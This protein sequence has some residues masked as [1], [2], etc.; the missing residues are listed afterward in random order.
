MLFSWKEWRKQR[1]KSISPST[2][3]R[4]NLKLKMCMAIMAMNEKN[5]TLTPPVINI[6]VSSGWKNNRSRLLPFLIEKFLSPTVQQQLVS[7]WGFAINLCLKNWCKF[8]WKS[9]LLKNIRKRHFNFFYIGNSKKYFHKTLIKF[10]KLF[11]SSSHS[12]QIR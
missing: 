5:S 3:M 9:I 8:Y 4:D 11:L 1:E 10:I 6:D 2:M 12:P 7:I